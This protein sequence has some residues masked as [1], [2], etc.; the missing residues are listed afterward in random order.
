[1][2]QCKSQAKCKSVSELMRPTVTVKS[3]ESM[4][5]ALDKLGS[6]ESL[7]AP[8]VDEMG[9][10]SGVLTLTDVDRYHEIRERYDGGD[11]SALDAVFEVDQ[12]GMRRICIDSFDHVKRH[13]TAPA[14]T[15]NSTQ[16]RCAARRVFEGN[17]AIHHLIVVDESNRPV[18]VLEKQDVSTNDSKKIAG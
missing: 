7:A 8:V 11:I 3:F 4:K 10:C 2:S 12:F 17:P 14:V 15:I 16:T 6:R 1:M 9:R 18:G 5:D 13:M